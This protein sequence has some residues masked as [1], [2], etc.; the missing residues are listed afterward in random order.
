[1][2]Q[3]HLLTLLQ[4]RTFSL[5]MDIDRQLGDIMQGVFFEILTVHIFEVES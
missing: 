5:L 3:F 2:S 4:P 1:M